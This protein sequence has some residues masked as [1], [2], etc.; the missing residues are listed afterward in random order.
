[1]LFTTVLRQRSQHY[2]FSRR[3]I[4]PPAD[5]GYLK[6]PGYALEESFKAKAGVCLYVRADVCC[7]R[8]SCLED[9]SFSM[10]AVHVDSGPLARVYSSLYRSHTGDA[11]TTRLFDHLSRAADDAQ[12]QFPN[13]ELVFLGALNAHH[14]DLCQT[15]AS[16]QAS[17][18]RSACSA[19]RLGDAN[20]TLMQ[21]VSYFLHE[22]RIRDLTDGCSSWFMSVNVG[23]PQGSVL[24]HTFFLLHIN[25]L[26]QLAN[27]HCCADD[28][29]L[30]ARYFGH[31]ASGQVETKDFGPHFRMGYQKLVEFNAQKTQVWRF[32]GKNIAIP[33]PSLSSGHNTGAT[34]QHYHTRYG[35]SLRPESK[36]LHRNL[37]QNSFTQ[38]RSPEQSAAFFH[39]RSTA[40]VVQNASAAWNIARTSGMA[41]LSTYSMPCIGC[42]GALPASL[43]MKRGPRALT[44][45][46]TDLLWPLFLHEQ[47]NLTHFF[48][49]LFCVGIIYSV[50]DA[51]L[52]GGDAETAARVWQWASWADS[53]LLPASCAWVFPYLGIMQFNKQ[54]V[55]RAKSD[56]LAA[57]KVLDSHLLPRTFLAGERPTLADVIVYCSLIHAYQY[58]LEPSIRSG[59]V[60]VTRWFLTL[61]NQP[62]VRAV[63]PPLTLC[64]AAPVLDPKKFQEISK[65]EGGK[66]EKKAEKKQEAKKEAPQPAP[67]EE[68]EEKPKEGKD[69]FDLMPKGTFNMDDFKRFYSNEE[70]AKSI[71]YF[72]EKFDPEH[73]SIWYAEYKYPEELAKVFMSCNLI[74]GMFQRLDKMRKQ[75]FASVC[76]FGSDNDSTISGVW[77]WRGQ[78]LAFT[79]SSD[80]QVDYESYDWTKLDP[81]DE[82]TKTLVKNYFSWTGTDKAGRPFNQG[83]VFK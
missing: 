32:H 16:L 65:K 34:E 27:T 83:K 43:A 8:L 51:K 19:L 1:M 30:H 49:V 15:L 59:L 44:F 77:V 14:K 13:A 22:R 47:R 81:K 3:Q 40:L 33:S 78:D 57:L 23:V 38:T 53:E 64:A 72:W 26:I 11:D 7:R 48:V 28:S 62:Q 10:L 39:P 17:C 31:A 35:S 55:E 46:V 56:L 58:V 54:N 61:A 24:S 76:L 20:S 2:C 74:T 21:E 67:E 60:N 12:A 42:S 9:P 63:T 37:D 68:F 18:I 52:R 45:V 82:K 6:Y 69:P 41:P 70:E 66:K 25:D 75:A 71:P 50:S 29:T 5:T 79:L 36:G 73:Y 80:W 4:L